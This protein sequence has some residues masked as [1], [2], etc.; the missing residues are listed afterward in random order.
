[1]NSVGLPSRWLVGEL[2]DGSPLVPDDR[3]SAI[4]LEVRFPRSSWQKVNT[5]RLR[6]RKSDSRSTG[7]SR[8][9]TVLVGQ[10]A[11]SVIILPSRRDPRA[12]AYLVRY[13]SDAGWQQVRSERGQIPQIPIEGDGL[14]R[15]E[16]R[17][18]FVDGSLGPWVPGPAIKG[19]T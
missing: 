14:V 18:E 11:A 2:D 6:L 3:A 12:S 4:E 5:Y 10:D 1:M 16:V 9:P 7:M 15:F 13:S 17:S 8:T 19:G